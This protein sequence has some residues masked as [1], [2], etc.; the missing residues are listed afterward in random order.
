[1][2]SIQAFLEQLRALL[3]VARD[4]QTFFRNRKFYGKSRI[5]AIFG[6]RR[7][8]ITSFRSEDFF[9]SRTVFGIMLAS[10]LFPGIKAAFYRCFYQMCYTACIKCAVA[11]VIDD[12]TQRFERA[13]S[14]NVMTNLASCVIA[15]FYCGPMRAGTLCS[16]LRK[17]GIWV[18]KKTL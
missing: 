9:F 16:N 4:C 11:C 10:L 7:G 12:V 14:D 1:M 6:A 13:R 17:A 15:L 18:T 5:G 8:S 3:Y 2:L